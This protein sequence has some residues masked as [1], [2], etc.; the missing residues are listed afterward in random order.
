MIKRWTLIIFILSWQTFAYSQNYQNTDSLQ[1]KIQ[2]LSNENSALKSTLVDMDQA[3][4]SRN[5]G[6]FFGM[7]G[8]ILGFVF[9][10]FGFTY[11]YRKTKIAMQKLELANTEL[12]DTQEQL[13]KSEQLAAFGVISTRLSHEILNP[14]NFVNNFSEL[15]QEM[16]QE[17]NEEEN[18]EHRQESLNQLSQTLGKINEHGKR[19]TS[20]VKQLQELSAKGTAHEFFEK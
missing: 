12:K 19:A 17:I 6:Y 4:G 7:A 2:K 5:L 14:L 11:Q 16:I 15:S 10:T 3:A 20:I 9:M 18:K 13:V 1:N 8:A